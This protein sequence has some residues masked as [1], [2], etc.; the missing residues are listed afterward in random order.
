MHECS[1]FALLH[2]ARQ[3]VDVIKAKK[4]DVQSLVSHQFQLEDFKAA[5]ALKQQGKNAMKIMI[6]P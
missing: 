2:T 4:I 3:A 5:F 6:I 1:C